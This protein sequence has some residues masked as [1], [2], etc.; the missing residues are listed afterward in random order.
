LRERFSQNG[1]SLGPGCQVTRNC[2][3][4]KPTVLTRAISR[5]RRRV[6]TDTAARTAGPAAT[7]EPM[8]STPTTTAIGT[9]HRRRNP[10]V[11]T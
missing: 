6:A 1:S 9:G 2:A 8:E 3:D 10:K 7:A 4:A 11:S 5:H